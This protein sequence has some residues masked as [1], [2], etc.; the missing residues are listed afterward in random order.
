[1][2]LLLRTSLAI[3]LSV[4]C[5]AVW[6]ADAI[7][8]A[9]DVR[10][11]L[12]DAC[13]HCHG[14]DAENQDS[15]FRADTE[16]NLFADLGGYAG[17]VPNKPEE[18][19]LYRR[20][21]SDD[22]GEVMP[23][24]DSHRSLTE[25]QKKTLKLWIEQGAPYAGHWAFQ[26]VR[27]PEVPKVSSEAHQNHNP[28]DA[29]VAE[30][31]RRED[32]TRSHR[33]DWATLLRRASLTL[34]GLLPPKE[35]QDRFLENP[36][37]EAFSKAVDELLD[38]Q[39]YAERQALRWLD[40]AR[41]ADTDGYQNDSERTNWPWRDW[42][43]KAYMENMP[44]D[45][46]TIEQIAGDMLDDA[47][48]ST[49]LASAFNRNHRQNAESG[50]LDDEFFVEN[51]IDRVE[52]TSTVWLGLT[53]G[54]ARCHDHKYDPI[55]QQ[56]FYQLF[57][58]FNN[59]GEKGTGRG[60]YANPTMKAFS[61]LVTPPEEL[62]KD[63][64]HKEQLLAEAGRG[65][66]SREKEWLT[67][68]VAKLEKNETEAGEAPA[69]DEAIAGLSKELRKIID[70]PSE[71]WSKDEKNRIRNHFKTK[72]PQYSQANSAFKKA[73]SKLFAITGPRVT[74]M[75]MRERAG[76]PIPAYYL[77][78]GQYNS[79]DKSRKMSRAV[80]AS[81]MVDADAPAPKDRL[82]FARWLVSRDNPLTARVIVNRIWQDHFGAGLV[83]TT[84]DF[85]VQ[86]DMPSHPDLLDWLSAE[87][88]ESGWDVKALHKLIVTSET[89]CQQSRT[90][91]ELQQR[92]PENRLL[93][94]GPR[95]RADG[96]VIR[97]LALQAG[98]LLNPKAGGPP[99]KPYQPD[100]L[101]ETLAANAGTKYR[102]AKG[103]DL[104]RKSL[105]TYWKRAVNPPRQTI[106]DGGG[107]EVCNVRV[108][109]T[110]TPLQA[111]V[112]LND[113]TMIEAARHLAGKTMGNGKEVSGNLASMYRGAIAREPS[114]KTLA[115]LQRNFDFFADHFANH[116]DDAAELL[117]IGESERDQNLDVN[118]HAAMTVVAHL[119]MNL[120]EF[121]TIE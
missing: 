66:E 90:T 106:F 2:N 100:G 40:A 87:F 57:S 110:N 46:F 11:I 95:Y 67:S 58:Y 28:I 119:I 8:F 3:S 13:F 54:C 98:G 4:L 80:P 91:K 99:V 105:Y 15:D 103:G 35:L 97:D 38:S 85:G 118:R 9:R 70:K 42:V 25:A 113:P 48:D 107:R 32:L 16:E 84:E 1:M 51:V 76:D 47:N 23:P 92:D 52:T 14:P 82:E 5:H 65:L 81:L 96:F 101:W 33:A 53:M 17:V 63:Y 79:P 74:V 112:L 27:R 68:V 30:R 94:R 56:E 22:E 55:S 45:Q 73:E 31:L 111:L 71:K 29:F 21:M 86:G 62:R 93:A 43:I 64:F 115:V 34:T 49:R 10:P 19:E 12:A 6:A 39:N 75:V 116:P 120:D 121:I 44:F 36:S 77:D 89:Y 69:G 20:V 72:D 37:Q 50:A 26:R 41:F 88:M 7:D 108:R 24:V 109:R 78:R 102:P 18:S 83:K 59:I 117:S 61:P 104:Y 114:D 60:V